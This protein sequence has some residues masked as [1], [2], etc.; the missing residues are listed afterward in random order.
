M[1]TPNYARATLNARL[2]GFQPQGDLDVFG[3]PANGWLRYDGGRPPP[4]MVGA[5][6]AEA[7][8]ELEIVYSLARSSADENG[9]LRA[10]SAYPRTE[11]L[12]AALESVA[13]QHPERPMKLIVSYAPKVGGWSIRWGAFDANEFFGKGSG[14]DAAIAD[15]VKMEAAGKIDRIH[16]TVLKNM[17]VRVS[18]S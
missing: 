10:A 4:E 3:E 9:V 17:S 6:L 18:Q 11:A 7:A 12:L 2:R 16:S 14:I 8:Q 1:G 15:S 13:P 5:L